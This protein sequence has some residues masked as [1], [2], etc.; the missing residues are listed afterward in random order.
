MG[1]M[2]NPPT[3]RTAFGHAPIFGLFNGAGDMNK[4]AIAGFALTLVSADAVAG[5]KELYDLQERCGR[6]AHEFFT[7]QYG[8]GDIRRNDGNRLL[9]TFENHYNQKFNKCFILLETV[10]YYLDFPTKSDNKS[11]TSWL[12]Y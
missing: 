11:T 5:P 9:A 3:A 4:L 12:T 7:K 10:Y 2:R 6:Q 8:S 1:R